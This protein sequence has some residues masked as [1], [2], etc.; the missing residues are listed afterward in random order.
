MF[1]ITGLHTHK[2]ELVRYANQ[3][4]EFK[5]CSAGNAEVFTIYAEFSLFH[6][7][8]TLAYAN[9]LNPKTAKHKEKTASHIRKIN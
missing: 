5:R 9:F 2:A 7:K 6:A 4:T 8:Q 1:S 3:T